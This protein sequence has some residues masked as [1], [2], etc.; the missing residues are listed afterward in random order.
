MAQGKKCPFCNYF[1]FAKEEKDEPMGSWVVYECRAC[2]HTEK[3][4]EPKKK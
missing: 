2:G 3:I 1:M 4:F